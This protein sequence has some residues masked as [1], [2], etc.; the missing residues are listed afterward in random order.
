[1]NVVQK[2]DRRSVG[3]LRERRGMKQGEGVKSFSTKNVFVEETEE[4]CWRD[5]RLL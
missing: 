3:I 2:K 4:R 1:M 5:D